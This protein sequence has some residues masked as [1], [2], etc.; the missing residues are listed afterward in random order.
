MSQIDGRYHGSIKRS[1]SEQDKKEQEQEYGWVS[2]WV[3]RGVR[4][5]PLFCLMPGSS[6]SLLCLLPTYLLCFIS[7]AALRCVESLTAWIAVGTCWLSGWLFAWM[8]EKE[9]DK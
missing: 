7:C 5:C 8:K 9:L 3:K 4:A 1:K 2:G 6:S